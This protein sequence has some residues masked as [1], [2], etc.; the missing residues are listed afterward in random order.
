M[1]PRTLQ[2]GSRMGQFRGPKRVIS[3]YLEVSRT[4]DLEIWTL[5][6]R[7]DTSSGGLQRRSLDPLG[8]VLE[9][10]FQAK[11]GDLR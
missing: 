5:I 10:V 9:I 2:K 8:P 6:S 11:R 3:S 4:S 1:T 7:S